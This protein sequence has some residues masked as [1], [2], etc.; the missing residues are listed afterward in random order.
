MYPFLYEYKFKICIHNLRSLS[1]ENANIVLPIQLF[2]LFNYN[3][4]SFEIGHLDIPSYHLF[5]KTVGLC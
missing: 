5:V 1:K 3:I 4:T 2:V